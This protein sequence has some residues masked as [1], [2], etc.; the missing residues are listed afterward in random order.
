MA[1]ALQALVDLA[2]HA[3]D[4]ERRHR[5]DVDRL[6]LLEAA[7]EAA[8]VGLGHLRV[9]LDA[10]EQRDVDVA[11][12]VDHLL[13]RRRAL[14]GARDLD[15]QVGAVDAVPVLARL[16][17]RALGVE[18]EIGIDLE[19]HEA[20]LAAALV[21]DDAQH[22]AGVLDVADRELLVDP[23]VVLAR[24][25]EL[26]ELLVVVVGA[27]DRRLK[28]VGLEVTPRSESSSTSRCSSPVLMRARLIWS[29]QMLVPAAVRAARRSLT[30][31]V[32]MGVSSLSWS[33]LAGEGLRVPA[34]ARRAAPPRGHP[35][36]GRSGPARCGSACRRPG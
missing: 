31:W 27:E 36:A 15:H 21:V 20:V 2:V 23:A 10:E 4:E 17:D 16:L 14:G 25:R 22:V 32:A 26:G 6:A 28:I 18:G 30:C 13:D 11:P 3:R 8:D 34:P 19:G 9:L 12:L 7:L 1:G 24:A 5:V 29:S 33:Q 35:P